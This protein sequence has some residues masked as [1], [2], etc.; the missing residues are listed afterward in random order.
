MRGAVFLGVVALILGAAA[1]RAI[2][3][4]WDYGQP[5]PYP[6]EAFLRPQWAY[7]VPFALVLS[8]PS[9][10]AVVRA[11][12]RV[13]PFTFRRSVGLLLAIIWTVLAVGLA[14]LA[15]PIFINIGSPG[16]GD[17]ANV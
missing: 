8:L 14:W 11:G 15:A 3:Y 6:N 16:P 17:P 5:L 9:A 13:P 12:S 10:F 4:S 7:I 1:T 2:A